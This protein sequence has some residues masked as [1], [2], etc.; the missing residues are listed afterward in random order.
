MPLWLSSRGQ[1]NAVPQIKHAKM[2]L[3]SW[4]SALWWPFLPIILKLFAEALIVTEEIYDVRE[5]D[6]FPRTFAPYFTHKLSWSVAFLR[7]AIA[8]LRYVVLAQG[9]VLQ[10]IRIWDHL[11]VNNLP[12][13]GTQKVLQKSQNLRL[14]VSC[15]S[16]THRRPCRWLL[17]EQLTNS[18]RF[19]DFCKTFS[20]PRSVKLLTVKC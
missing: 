14:F 6:N 17:L 8:I 16:N 2:H 5:S 9:N 4:L 19:F 13:L 20:F 15:S 1:V 18:H 7:V 3:L 11:I 12:D 10:P